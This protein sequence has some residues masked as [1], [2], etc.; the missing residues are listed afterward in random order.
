MRASEL[1]A[2]IRQI[3]Q[4]DNYFTKIGTVDDIPN[5]ENETFTIINTE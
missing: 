4:L 2:L 3:P 1:E 5:L